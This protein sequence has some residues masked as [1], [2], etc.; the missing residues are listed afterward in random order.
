M[1]TFHTG[2]LL[3]A[4]AQA[5]VNTVNTVGV[6]GK[7][8]ALQFKEKFPSNL[9][10]YIKACKNGSLVP[11]KLLVVKENTLEGGE[12]LIINFPTK[13]DWRHKS[14][15]KFIEEGLQAL[16][17]VIAEYDIKSIAIP[18]LGCGNG[19]LKW[20]K[21]KPLME[22][23]LSGLQ[24]VDIQIYEPN[25]EVKAILQQ[26]AV[27]KQVKLTPARAIFLYSMFAYEELGEPASLFVANKLAYFIQLLGEKKMRLNFAANKYGPYADEVR[28]VLYALNGAYLSGMEQQSTRPF[29]HVTLKYEKLTEIREYVSRELDA[30]QRLRLTQV[31]KL[32]TGFESALSLEVLSTVAFVLEKNPSYNEQQVLDAVYDWADREDWAMRKRALMPK[33][34]IDIA[35]HHL[36]TYKSEM[37]FA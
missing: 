16:V 23:Y 28:H 8:I 15:Y 3:R 26:Q 29:E 18:P 5:L 2:D 10:E 21:V 17:T 20:E 37:M 1:I 4:P 7:G 14:T 19:G 24:D 27:P 25:A 13:V 36:Q 22:Q 6:M 11:G 33:R 31:L 35:Y 30:E 9:K 12:Q 32:I 34:Y